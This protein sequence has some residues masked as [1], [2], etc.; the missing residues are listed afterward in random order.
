MFE[1]GDAEKSGV[2]IEFCETND[3]TPVAPHVARA[4]E[5]QSS[6]SGVR[7]DASDAAGDTRVPNAAGDTDL[8]ADDTRRLGSIVTSGDAPMDTSGEAP[9]DAC[10]AGVGSFGGGGGGGVGGFATGA[11]A[12]ASFAFSAANMESQVGAFGAR[13]LRRDSTGTGGFLVARFGGAAAGCCIVVWLA[14]E[15]RVDRLRGFCFLCSSSSAAAAA[16][17]AAVAAA[18]AAAARVCTVVAGGFGS[19]D[20]LGAGLDAMRLRSAASAGSAQ[21]VIDLSAAKRVPLR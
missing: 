13:D 4:F 5:R 20:G 9:I 12:G 11:G 10:R 14:L 8:R 16:V 18:A 6:S 2:R 21:K 3:G 7:R 19:R 15:S 1:R 17:A